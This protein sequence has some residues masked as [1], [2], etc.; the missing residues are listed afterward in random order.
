MKTPTKSHPRVTIVMSA[1]E[2]HAL[3]ETAIESIVSETNRP[4]RFIYLDVQSPDWLRESF[5]LRSTEWGL[6]VV[7]FD[8]PLWPQEARNRIVNTIDTDY[9]VFIDNDV[10][11]E[12]GWLDSLVACADDTD[13]GIV[14]P[15]YLQGDGIRPAKIHMAGGVLTEAA[16]EHG[17]V[18]GE[19]HF[20]SHMDAKQADDLLCR[21]RCDFV[22]YHCMLIRTELLRDG[23]LLDANI[24]CVHEHID[25]ALSVKQRGYSVFIE[26]STRVTYLA[27]SDYML[28]DLL[29][30]RKRW[31]SVEAEA[32]ID[33][34]CRKWNVVNDDRSFG[35]VRRFVRHHVAQVDPIRSSPP[36]AADHHRPMQREELKQTRSDLL[37]FASERGY[38]THELALIAKS[39]H[40]AH[41]VTDGG[42]RPC[43]RPFANHLVGTASVLVRYGFRAET[44][45][46]GLL[47]SAYTHSPPHREGPK[48]AM[49]SVYALLGGKESE[50]ERRVRAYTLRESSW[51]G[52]PTD[53][54]SCSTLSI[55][56]SEIIAIAVANEVEMHLSGEIRY[57]GR[58]DD[59][60]PHMLRQ[61]SH[62]C[63][64]F[65]VNG[66]SDTM[67]LAQ[68]REPFVRPELMTNTNVSYRIAQDKRSAVPMA[69]NDCTALDQSN[70]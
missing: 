38:Q 52:V 13:A 67:V 57:S 6:E 51:A 14:G 49:N 39:Y 42:Y 47:H 46:A 68:R 1:R 17:R 62:V 61:M 10:L 12:D 23:A 25:T 11:V 27:F 34:F 32:N 31:S 50:V 35:G 53:S 3:A 59:I 29:F 9:V 56:E 60:K 33:A 58:N 65:G 40:L 44:V 22:E 69:T 66:L 2:R 63:Q 37:D 24:R 45:A 7:R 26:P 20:L 70:P 64:I 54:D 8:E 43:G 21:R 16:A 36:R 5:A 19:Q 48:A 4:Y 55:F 41:I 30:F 28:D 15:L 18:L